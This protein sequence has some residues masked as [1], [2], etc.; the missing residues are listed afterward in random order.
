[1][2][3]NKIII[4]NDIYSNL[5]DDLKLPTLNTGDVGDGVGDGV[6]TRVGNGVGSGVGNGVGDGV[7]ESQQTM[8]RVA[9]RKCILHN[10][11]K[12]ERFPT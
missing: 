8:V 1:M 3:E 6:G 12:L 7:F 2:S 11:H 9:P 10:M 5:S 4:L